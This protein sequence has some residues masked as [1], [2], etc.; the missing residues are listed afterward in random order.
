M[1]SRWSVLMGGALSLLSGCV[2]HAVF[3]GPMPVRNQHPAQQLVLHLPAAGAEVLG[4]GATEWRVG[5]AY[6]SLFLNGSGAG[7]TLSLDGEYL[8]T[9][10]TARIGLGADL[11]LGLDLPLAHTSGGFLDSFVIDWHDFW[12]FPD[13]DRSIAPR[14][15]W[16]VE[17]THQGQ[18]AFHVGSE[19]LQ[20]MDVPVSLTLELLPPGQRQLG[21]AV[22]SGIELPTGNQ[23]RGFGNGGFD[24]GFGAL[25]EWRESWIALTGQ[26]QHTFAATPDRAAA[27]GLEFG[28][29]T[30][31][32]FGAELP[33]L[34]GCA[35][36]VQLGW[37]TS[38]LRDLDFARAA[39]QQL[40][41]WS[42]ARIDLA[43]DW[44]LELSVGE[45]LAAF[46]SPDFTAWASLV[47]RPSVSR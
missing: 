32:D 22:R 36:V 40:L 6:S 33:L 9:D 5:A 15:R 16:R 2:Q 25:A 23:S 3:R 30:A 7:N 41:L 13:Q 42:G 24:Y 17:A 11:E 10:L 29:V 21:L 1:R 4:P 47:F 46:V 8:R 14:R 44:Q 28:D 34:P 20:V 26:V 12:G 35:A 27:S 19:A 39:R 18:S 45:D 43:A 31:A 37:E 38:T